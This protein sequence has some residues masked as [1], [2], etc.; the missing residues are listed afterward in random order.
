M[1]ANNGSEEIVAYINN[2]PNGAFVCR[3]ELLSIPHELSNTTVDHYR[4]LL[5][6]NG[7]MKETDK[8]GRYEKTKD[9]PKSITYSMMRKFYE[10][11]IQYQ[12]LRQ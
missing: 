8:P 1:S 12:R 3:K 10:I 7:C 9:I 11:E 4:R 2:V 5:T 6:V